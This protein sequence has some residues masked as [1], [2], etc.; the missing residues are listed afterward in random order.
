MFWIVL[1]AI[2][3]PLVLVT[4]TLIGTSMVLGRNNRV[5]STVASPAP[6]TWLTSG[7]KEAKL[8]RRLR[9]AGRRLE[10]IPS[11]ED[12]GDVIAGLQVELVDL[13]SYLVTVARRPAP[14]RRADRGIVT[15]RV[16]AIEDLVR[17]VEERSR[18]EPVSLAELTERLDALEAADEE[19]R[20]LDPG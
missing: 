7:R 16:E 19:L 2:L 17:R 13:D 20:G 15:E 1:A 4:A 10:L 12:V 3:I 8:H 11:T 6:L 5:V 14:N 9:G 18:R